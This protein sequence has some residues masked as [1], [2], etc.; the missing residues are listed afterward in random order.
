MG[1]IKL[2]LKFINHGLVKT[3]AN[4]IEKSLLEYPKEERDKVVL[5]FSAHSL[6]MSVVDRGGII[7]LIFDPYPAEVAGTVAA[8]ME[9]LNF[10]NPYRLVW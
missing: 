6:P 3:F 1:I 8:I 10:S 4:H 5:L 7:N 2:I 9:R